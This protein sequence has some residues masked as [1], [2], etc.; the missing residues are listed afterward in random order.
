MVDGFSNEAL[1]RLE[2]F[3]EESMQERNE[4]IQSQ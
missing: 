2:R 1:M 3:G 4:A